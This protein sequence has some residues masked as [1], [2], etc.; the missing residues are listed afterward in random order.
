MIIFT[1]LRF[2]LTLPVVVVLL[3]MGLLLYIFGLRTAA[4]VF[5]ALAVGL[6]MS[7]DTLDKLGDL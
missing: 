2:L 1:V 4:L 3:Q 5:V 6:S 7:V